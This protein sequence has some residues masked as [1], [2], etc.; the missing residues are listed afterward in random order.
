MIFASG[1]FSKLSRPLGDV[2]MA[3][4]VEAP[5]LHAVLLGPFQR[6]RIQRSAGA[7]VS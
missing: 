1:L 6:H 2:A 5:A 7:I 4:A 3:G